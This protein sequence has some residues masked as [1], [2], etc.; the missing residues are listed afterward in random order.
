[1]EVVTV[2]VRRGQP[3]FEKMHSSPYRYLSLLEYICVCTI[4]VHLLYLIN[5]QYEIII[6]LAVCTL[7]STCSILH[8]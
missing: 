3:S 7:R 1:M 2:S 8:G 4:H 5:F 6:T